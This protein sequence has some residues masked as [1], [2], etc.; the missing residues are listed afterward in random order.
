MIESNRASSSENDVRIRHWI[1]P[2]SERTSRQTSTPLP[3][4]SR[5]STIATSG[6]VG[7]DPSDALGRRP[8]L[9]DD[10]DVVVR[11]EELTDPAPDDLVVVQQEHPNSSWSVAPGRFHE[12]TRHA[13]ADLPLTPPHRR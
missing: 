3:S 7:G 13:G 6:L 8:G 9:A 1:E 10:L 5:M 11:L 4:G 2:S 12:G